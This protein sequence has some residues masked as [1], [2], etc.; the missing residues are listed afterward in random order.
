MIMHGPAYY[1][2]SLHPTSAPIL[3]YCNLFLKT[4]YLL[5]M[6]LSEYKFCVNILLKN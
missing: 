4:T 5:L 2:V 1:Y 3:Y 6:L